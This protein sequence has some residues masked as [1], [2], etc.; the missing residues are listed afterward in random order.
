M[1]RLKLGAV[2]LGLALNSRQLEQFNI[3]YQELMDARKVLSEEESLKNLIANSEQTLAY[4][5]GKYESYQLKKELIQKKTLLQRE[6][7]WAQVGKQEQIVASW[8]DKVE[9]KNADISELVKKREKIKKRMS[10][11]K[12]LLNNS[13]FEQRKL[14][15]RHQL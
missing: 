12:D 3:Y 2:K 10:A 1:E 13:R 8:N 9:Q 15:Y 4:W 7:I 11:L 5:R 6:L 14:V